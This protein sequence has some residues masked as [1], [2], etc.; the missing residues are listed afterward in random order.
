VGRIADAAASS[1]PAP[2]GPVCQVC[3]WIDA[4]GAEDRADVD[5]LMSKPATEFGHSRL[6][7]ILVAELGAPFP[8]TAIG[9][10]RRKGHRG[11]HS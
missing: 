10:C 11:S 4:L 8:T 9:D 2:H 7:K 5:M 3:R 1:R 6:H